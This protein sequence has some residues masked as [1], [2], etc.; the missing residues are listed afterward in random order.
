VPSYG[1]EVWKVTECKRRNEAAKMCFQRS[2]IE[3]ILPDQKRNE[4]NYAG[5][6]N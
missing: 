4:K 6:T 2:V 1:S 5:I 3:I